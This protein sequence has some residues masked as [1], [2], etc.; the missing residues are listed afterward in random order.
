MLLG[1]SSRGLGILVVIEKFSKVGLLFS[2]AV[3]FAVPS[4]TSHTSKGPIEILGLGVKELQAVQIEG[5]IT[6][7][8]PL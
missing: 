6:D 8:T 3:F 2:S 7:V 4:I 1:H 5:S